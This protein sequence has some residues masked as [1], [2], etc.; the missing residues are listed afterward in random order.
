MIKVGISKDRET[1]EFR[2]YWIDA[3]RYDEPKTSYHDDP[4]DAAGTLLHVMNH[5]PEVV[6][7]SSVLT[8]SLMMRY[9]PD[10]TR[11]LASQGRV[12]RRS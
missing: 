11:H 4:D 5:Y 8:T 6:M 9:F 10:A 2:V 3:G 7:S 12:E 1:G